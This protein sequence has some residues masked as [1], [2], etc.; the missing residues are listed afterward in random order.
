M[1]EDHDSL[2]EAIDQPALLL[3]ENPRQVVAA[4][5]RAL[6]LFGKTHVAGR[7]GGEVFDCIHAFSEAGCGKDPHCEPCTIK[8][9][10][11]NTFSTCQPHRSVAAT[12]QVSKAEGI[13]PYTLQVS[14]EKAGD[15]ALVRIE[16]FAPEE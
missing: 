2:L 11:V 16:R 4:N 7:R 8:G 5:Q 10:I 3:Q 12:L 15:L 13:R 1:T 6:A 14:T 9:A